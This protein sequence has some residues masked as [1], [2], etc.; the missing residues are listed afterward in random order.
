MAVRFELELEQL[1]LDEQEAFRAEYGM[2][3]GAISRFV[4]R[5][6]EQLN[7]V[8]FFTTTGGKEV[9]A[10]AVLDGTTV[11]SAAGKIHS[12]MEEKFNKAEVYNYSDLEEHGTEKDIRA[13]G[14][15][16]VEGKDYVVQ[17]GDIVLVKF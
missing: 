1:P 4:K 16:R 7:L 15:L 17:D 2:Q 10:T 9:R 11:R 13:A 12:D 5:V 14:K 8:T 3:E 6:Y